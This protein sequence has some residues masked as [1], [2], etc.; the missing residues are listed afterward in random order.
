ML[1]P[2]KERLDLGCRMLFCVQLPAAAYFPRP[3]SFSGR[4]WTRNARLCYLLA[5]D[6][7]AFL[8]ASDLVLIHQTVFGLGNYLIRIVP[9]DRVGNNNWNPHW[10]IVVTRQCACFESKIF[11]IAPN[12]KFYFHRSKI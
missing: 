7:I 10:S 12:S 8:F 3:W 9:F 2:R 4:Q 5:R 6:Q 11:E 1:S